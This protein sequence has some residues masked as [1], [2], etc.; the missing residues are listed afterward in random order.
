MRHPSYLHA[1][2]SANAGGHLH[3]LLARRCVQPGQPQQHVRDRIGGVAVGVQ[4]MVWLNALIGWA[5]RGDRRHAW[6]CV[7]GAAVLF[8]IVVGA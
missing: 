2:Q 4:T 3:Q 7:A 8:G 1:E 6:V 5:R